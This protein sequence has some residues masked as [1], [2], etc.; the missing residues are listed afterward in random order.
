[1]KKLGILNGIPKKDAAQQAL[2]NALDILHE[3]AY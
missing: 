1:M 3:Y 2:N